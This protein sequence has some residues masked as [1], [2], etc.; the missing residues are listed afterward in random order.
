V[1][2]FVV[3]PSCGTRIKA[4]REFCLRCFEPLPTSD[5]PVRLPIWVSLG[6]SETKKQMVA[7]GAG[8][9]VV[10]LLAI[11]WMTEPARVDD[12]ARPVVAPAA[13]SNLPTPAR[14][15]T[16][17]PGP[18]VAADTIGGAPVFE[19]TPIGAGPI[20]QSAADL[21]ALE[22]KRAAAEA[23]LVKRPDD[24]GLLNDLGQALTGLG[25]PG[26]AVPRFERAIE[27][28]PDNARYHTNLARAA[29]QAGLWDR[30][31]GEYREAARLRPQDF[32]VQYTLAL[33]LHRKGDDAAA[34][35]EFQRAIELGANDAGVHLSAG[36]SL[37]T[38]GRIDEAVREYRK[39]L[40]LQPDS[41]DAERLKAHL[42]ALAPGNP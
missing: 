2:E 38:V 27:L 33:T 36:V 11:I 10:A 40:V 5:R 32:I 37:E 14:S 34:V 18:P 31:V 23:E 39:Y 6:L 22:S 12:T 25:R 21:A 9:A 42:L 17:T 8:A 24:V 15:S 41:T 1:D 19:P 13:R 20:T 29:F 26:D 28:A 16:P 7:G 3:C 30:A 35:A 4:G